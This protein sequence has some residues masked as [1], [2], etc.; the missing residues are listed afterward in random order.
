MNGAVDYFEGT[1][2]ISN[3]KPHISLRFKD[4]F[5]GVQ[6]GSTPPFHLKDRPSL[7]ADLDWFMHRYPLDLTDDAQRRLSDQLSAHADAQARIEELKRPDYTPSIRPGFKSPEKAEGYQ[8]RAAE[9]LRSTGSLLLMDDVGLGK[10]VSFLASVSDG[11]GLPAAVVVQ[12]HLSNQWV[13]EY[14]ERF[15]HL[16]AYEVKDRNVRTLPPA[17]IYLFR[18]SNIA[19][20]ADYAGTLGIKTVCFDEIQELRHGLST[21]KGQGAKAF[22]DAA[23]YR[24]GLTATPIYN[25]GSEIWNVV[26][27]IAPDAL[28]SWFE[29][30][31][32]WCTS[33]GAHWIVKDPSALGSYL[34]D[35]G[36]ALRR[37]NEDPEVSCTLPPL[38]KLVIEV[39][40]NEGD[41][42]SNRELQKR[43]AQRILSGTF[44]E[45]GQAAR[46]LD[47]M[48]RQ[49]TGIAKART[50]AAYV[51]TMV[52]A[53]EPVLLAG[54]H[55]GVYDIWSE[56]LGDLS[57]VMFTG[58]ETQAQKRK[59]KQAFL[60]GDSPLMIM[61]LR[62]GA[63]LDGLQHVC[64]HVVYGE[65]DWSPQVHTQFTGRV[66]RRG[67]QCPV[68]AH[69]LHVDGGSDPVIM[70]TLGL[71][72]SQSHG[73]L[74][75]F[76]DMESA[77]PLE[78]TRM[79]ALAKSVLEAKGNG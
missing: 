45:R 22:C 24:I 79:R 29:F 3:L 46:E 12:P 11:W 54:W 14:I 6:F 8:L 23:D 47:V 66:R 61:S 56:A 42:A 73:I 58:S 19:A 2:R 34:V 1:W 28:G 17:D 25:Y 20:W 43:L 72:A 67:Q 44:H 9:M 78:D 30:Q 51:R 62:S 77:T 76:A 15:T 31:I 68:T 65:M 18:Y 69:F 10:T 13:K 16:T 52:E 41:A 63:G 21:D 7:A 49:E 57:P 36:I 70:S 55:R 74:N 50:V 71:K 4:M 5:K 35:E 48:M 27:F 75:P 60:S 59:A 32:N 53:G 64:R 38:S 40:W 26:Q 33:H 39:G 37:T